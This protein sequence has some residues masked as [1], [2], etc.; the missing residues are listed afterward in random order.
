MVPVSALAFYR[1]MHTYT[2]AY[3]HTCIHNTHADTDTKVEKEKVN[4]SKQQCFQLI[5]RTALPAEVSGVPKA[6][7]IASG[8]ALLSLLELYF[9]FPKFLG[10]LPSFIH[11]FG[12]E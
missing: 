3:M 9:V 4:S 5:P 2:H 7:E 11:S 10:V 12:L 8:V 1:Y 6:V